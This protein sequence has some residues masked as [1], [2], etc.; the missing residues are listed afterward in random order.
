MHRVGV[1]N[2]F[3][4]FYIT[5]PGESDSEYVCVARDK[6]DALKQHD[7]EC[8]PFDPVD[9]DWEAHQLSAWNSKAWCEGYMESLS[10]TE[11]RAEEAAARRKS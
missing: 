8:G 5:A 2:R 4:V 10:D 9:E 7:D 3:A 1:R 6:S 11:D